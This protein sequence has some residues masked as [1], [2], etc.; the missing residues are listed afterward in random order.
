MKRT[1]A[2]KK[3]EL[4]THAEAVIERLL[5]WEE[6]TERPNLLQIEEVVLKLRKRLGKRLAEMVVEEQEA[7]QPAEPPRCPDCGEAMRY[8]GR[9]SLDVESRVGALDLERGYYHCACCQSGLFPPGPT[10]AAVGEE[11]E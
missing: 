6:E 8:K 7:V 11:M 10:T 4:M 2:Q 3:A 5:D 1:R 9:K